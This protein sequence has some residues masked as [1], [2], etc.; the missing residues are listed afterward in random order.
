M[1]TKYAEVQEG[2]FMK[3]GG[4]RP[5]FLKIEE[6]VVNLCGGGQAGVKQKYEVM[7]AAGWRYEPLTSYGKNPKM[8]TAVFNKINGVLESAT[9][10]DSLLEALKGLQ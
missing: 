9:D 8:A 7:K 10:K 1:A 3:I 4:E 2:D 5:S 6:E